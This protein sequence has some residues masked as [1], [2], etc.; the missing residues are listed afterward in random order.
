MTPQGVLPRTVRNCPQ[1][2]CS[3]SWLEQSAPDILALPDAKH[4]EELA[5]Q[6]DLHTATGIWVAGRRCENL[7]LV[8][9]DPRSP[10]KI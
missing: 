6:I 1:Q 10:A 2:A 3:G 4:L 7:K 5:A 8:Y 9:I